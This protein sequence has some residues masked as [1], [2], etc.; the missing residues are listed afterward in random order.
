MFL[1]QSGLDAQ[2]LRRRSL[3]RRKRRSNSERSQ[4]GVRELSKILPTDFFE[5]RLTLRWFCSDSRRKRRGKACQWSFDRAI[6][7]SEAYWA[8]PFWANQNPVLVTCSLTLYHRPVSRMKPGVKAP[9]KTPSR[10]LKATRDPYPLAT[11]WQARTVP[12]SKILIARYFESVYLWRKNPC[13]E[14]IWREEREWASNQDQPSCQDTDMER[15]RADVSDVEEASNCFK[16]KEIK[17]RNKESEMSQR[18][19]L[20]FEYSAEVIPKSWTIP[21]SFP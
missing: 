19:D 8:V 12:H 6:E 5:Y 16:R 3:W 10:I 7:T 18:W 9:S 13:E 1:N 20:R 15:R 21:S 4:Y 14:V 2:V 17:V 11:A